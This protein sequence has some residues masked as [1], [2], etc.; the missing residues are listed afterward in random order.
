VEG[1]R[2]YGG[3][4]RQKIVYNNVGVKNGPLDNLTF[5]G[6][7]VGGAT[8]ATVQGFFFKEQTKVNKKKD[9]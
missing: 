1:P 9:N 3:I 2:P 4:N 5:Q 7:V 6:E 8:R